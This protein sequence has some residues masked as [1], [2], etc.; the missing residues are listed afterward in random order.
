MFLKLA[1]IIGALWLCML[2]M[3]FI[4]PLRPIQ[5]WLVDERWVYLALAL[6]S[7][8]ILMIGSALG[9]RNALGKTFPFVAIPVAALLGWIAIFNDVLPKIFPPDRVLW[10]RSIAGATSM[11]FAKAALAPGE[12]RR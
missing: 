7:A 11:I 1:W 5:D 9:I 3:N 6:A 2:A 10:I 8:S 12:E 4:P